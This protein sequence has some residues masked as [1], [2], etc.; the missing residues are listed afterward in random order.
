MA[1]ISIKDPVRRIAY[2]HLVAVAVCAAFSLA[3]WGVLVNRE[4]SQFYVDYCAI[5]ILPSLL[6]LYVMPLW[7]LFLVGT[8]RVSGGNAVMGIVVETILTLAHIYSVLPLI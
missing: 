7:M 2:L 5:L 4:V 6:A 3:A 1:I 8:A